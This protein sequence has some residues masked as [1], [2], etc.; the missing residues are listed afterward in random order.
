MWKYRE[1][2]T[3]A[4]ATLLTGVGFASIPSWQGALLDVCHHAAVAGLVTIALFFVTRRMG[5]RGIAL[6]RTWSALFLAGMPVST[7]SPG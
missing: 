6:E 3:L 2:V 5:P 7:S 4:V 1:Q